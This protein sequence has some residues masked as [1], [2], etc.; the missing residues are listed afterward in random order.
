MEKKTFSIPN[1]SCGHCVMSI[2]NEL[3]ELEGVKSVEGNPE[4]KSIDVQW[5]APITEDKI[6]ETLKEINYPAA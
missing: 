4:A 1:I 6:K 2:K 3:S 5:D